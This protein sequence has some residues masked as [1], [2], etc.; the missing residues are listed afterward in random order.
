MPNGRQLGT[1]RGRHAIKHPPGWLTTNCT[2]D[3]RRTPS[4]EM[5]RITSLSFWGDR[6]FESTFLQRRVTC[7]LVLAVTRAEDPDRRLFASAGRE[8]TERQYRRPRHPRRQ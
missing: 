8:M 4:S 7:E 6:G 5:V 1:R 2:W 3:Q